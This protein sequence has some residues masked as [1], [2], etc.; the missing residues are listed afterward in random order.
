MDIKDLKL[1]KVTNRIY[2]LPNLEAFDWPTLGLVIGDKHTLMLDSGR[3][4]RHTAAFLDR[5]RQNNLPM[6]DMCAI[7][8]WHWD[9][10]YGLA[11]LGNII[12]FA[13]KD[14]IKLIRNMQRWGWSDEEM[15]HRIETGEDLE[16][17]YPNINAEYPDKSQI[18]IATPTVEYDDHLTVDLGGVHAQMK[19]I[20]NS[21]S[22]DSRV[23]YIPEEKTIFLGDI[24]YEDLLPIRPVY[25]RNK[26]AKLM[27]GLQKMDFDKAI[28]GH[29]PLMTGD[30]IYNMLAQAELIDF[31]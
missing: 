30:E 24:C 15:R 7:T 29:Q 8:H 10:T 21:H 26:H 31:E 9:H 1:Q 17:S 27:N 2:Y 11:S 19:V 14:T 20:E 18:K 5:L 13:N 4:R 12:S 23:I 28:P 3:S 16:F 25:Y 6:P 22:Y